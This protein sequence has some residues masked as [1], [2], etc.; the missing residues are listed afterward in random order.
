MDGLLNKNKKNVRFRF[1]SWFF[2]NHE[3]IKDSSLW[4][5][6]FIPSVCDLVIIIALVIPL[7]CLSFINI[8]SGLLSK[9]EI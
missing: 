2:K 9:S 7:V 1:F 3:F 5:S 8:G 4:H 6:N